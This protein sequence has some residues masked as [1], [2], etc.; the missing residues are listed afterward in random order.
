[1]EITFDVKNAFFDRLAVIQRMDAASVKRLSKA[2]AMVRRT[3]R[4]LVRP[5]KRA[6]R[7]GEPPSTHSPEPNLRTVLFAYDKNA[8]SVVVGPVKLNQME[9][10]WID[11]TGTT[12]PRILEHG[13]RVLVHEW[14][15]V[16]LAAKEADPRWDKHTSTKKFSLEWRRRDKRWGNG[17]RK[18]RGYYLSDLGTQVRTRRIT[19]RAR[20]FMGPALAK[21]QAKIPE[22]FRNCIGP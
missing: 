21:E 5:R 13:D 16:N 7:P 10:S 20:P 3:A 15:F 9:W 6:S 2:G 17:S 4:T 12:V 8:N 11:Y 1:M 18:R 14:R 19:I 22:L